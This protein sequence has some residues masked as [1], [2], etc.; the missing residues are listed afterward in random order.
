MFKVIMFVL[1]RLCNTQNTNYELYK[2]YNFSLHPTDYGYIN[3]EFLKKI[4]KPYD[5]SLHPTDY[6][7]INYDF[8]KEINLGKGYW[9]DNNKFNWIHDND[10]MHCIN[11]ECIYFP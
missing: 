4:Y 3:Y 7:Y 2:P 5:F 9:N 6:G 11:G 8:G 10:N 1:F